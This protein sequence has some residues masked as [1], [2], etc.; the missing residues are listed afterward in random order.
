MAVFSAFSDVPLSAECL[1]PGVSNTVG[2]KYVKYV[3]LGGDCDLTG[4]N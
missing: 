4:R 2:I 1:S 3:V